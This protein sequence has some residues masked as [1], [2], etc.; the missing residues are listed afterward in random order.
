MVLLVE[1]RESGAHCRVLPTLRDGVDPLV[2]YDDCPVI[3]VIA[4]HLG[5]PLD[6]LVG[7]AFS[8]CSLEVFLGESV[9]IQSNEADSLIVQIIRLARHVVQIRPVCRQNEVAAPWPRSGERR[10]GV[11]GTRGPMQVVV[12]RNRNTGDGG[13]DKAQSVAPFAPQTVVIS[14]ADQVRSEERRARKEGRKTWA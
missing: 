11:R 3:R 6:F 14:L 8:C 5:E 13:G 7:D 2:L 4:Q 12:A 9:H 1:R 10:T